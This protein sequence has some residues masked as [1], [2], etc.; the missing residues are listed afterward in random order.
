MKRIYLTLIL[1]AFTA[2]GLIVLIE[3]Q[4][5][6]PVRFRESAIWLLGTA[7]IL[8]LAWRVRT[9]KITSLRMG[10]GKR[11]LRKTLIFGLILTPL[12]ILWLAGFLMLADKYYPGS[13]Y[14]VAVAFYPFMAMLLVGVGCV[15]V[16]A[17][18][19]IYR[20]LGI[21]KYPDEA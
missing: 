2:L 11:A 10:P 4:K 1:T 15:T 13:S 19:K 12:S 6:L 9:G 16:P 17:V 5:V 20:V 8:W 21:T 7:A 14:A 3:F 18:L